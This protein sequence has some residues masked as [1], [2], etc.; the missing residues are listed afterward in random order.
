M[1]LLGGEVAH[2]AIPNPA[3]VVEGG[4]PHKGMVSAIFGRSRLN[5]EGPLQPDTSRSVA[6][7]QWALPPIP[8]YEFD[9]RIAW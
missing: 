6:A 9:Q 8:A 1:G 5:A 3:L 7:H 2:S 4:P